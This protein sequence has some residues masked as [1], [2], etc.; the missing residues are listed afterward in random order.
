MRPLTVARVG[1]ALA[2]AIEALGVS[3]VLEKLN[4]PQI[5]HLPLSGLPYPG[6]YWPVLTGLWL[7]AAAGLAVNVRGSG[8][9]LAGCLAYVVLL[10]QQTYSNHL[11]LFAILAA[12]V[13][14]KGSH[15]VLAL[16]GQ[17]TLVYFFAAVS[18]LNLAF[19]SGLVIA[20][21]L[22]PEFDWLRTPWLLIPL[23][24]SAI[25]AELFIA[26]S[27]W[28]ARRRLYAAVVGI[29]MHTSFVVL[30]NNAVPL[31]AFGI[32]CLSLYPLF[33]EAD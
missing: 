22:R 19:L 8:W 3:R 33:W 6:A 27:L 30:M 9:L 10:D 16:K 13:T 21:S 11:Y 4:E 17:L 18:K 32:A 25:V 1:V 24:I 14:L 2:S 26:D 31:T 5:V 20:G 15:V 28:V 7:L 29:M 12:L 23:A